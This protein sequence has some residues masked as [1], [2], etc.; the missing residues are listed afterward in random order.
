MGNVRQQP[1]G[2]PP[3]EVCRRSTV[4]IDRQTDTGTNGRTEK[5]C[6]Q[7][8]KTVCR[9]QVVSRSVTPREAGAAA[10]RGGGRPSRGADGAMQLLFFLG[11]QGRPGGKE[12]ARCAARGEEQVQQQERVTMEQMLVLRCILGGC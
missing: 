5:I 7:R 3:V 1:A 8:G 4:V 11:D 6:R 2:R 10:H 12:T 9:W